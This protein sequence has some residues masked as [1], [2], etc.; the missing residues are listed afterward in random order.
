MAPVAAGVEIHLVANSTPRRLNRN[1]QFPTPRHAGGAASDLQDCA[2]ATG[3]FREGADR[4][5]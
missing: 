5:P 4:E 3:N 2:T 1:T